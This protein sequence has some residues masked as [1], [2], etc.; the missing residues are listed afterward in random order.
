[1]TYDSESMPAFKLSDEWIKVQE[2]VAAQK[3]AEGG[4]FFSVVSEAAAGSIMRARVGAGKTAFMRVPETR[5]SFAA[6]HQGDEAA[7]RQGLG[8]LTSQQEAMAEKK[9]CQRLQAELL[10]KVAATIVHRS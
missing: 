8:A 7:M 5:C 4:R 1:M 6:V 10:Q 9:E 3:A 2:H